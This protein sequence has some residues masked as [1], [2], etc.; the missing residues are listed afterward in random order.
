MEPIVKGM[1][2]AAVE[3]VQDRLVS[4]GYT[5]SQQERDACEFG[6]TT[7]AAVAAFRAAQRLDPGIEVDD[8][9]WSVLVDECYSLGDRTLYL[10]LPNFHGRDVRELQNALNILGFS[11]GSTDGYYDP[12]TESA[13]KQ[14]QDS[15]GLLADGLAFP[16]TFAAI[17]SLHHVWA[18][19]P[20]EGPHPTGDI[21]F[22]RAAVVLESTQISITAEDPITRNV[23]GRVWNLAS[24]TTDASRLALV[25]NAQEG[26]PDDTCLLILSS[27]AAKTRAKTPRVILEDVDTLPQR[28]RTAFRSSRAKVPTVRIALPASIG[29]DGSFTTRD[30]QAL[31]VMLLDGIC[32]AFAEHPL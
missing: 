17:E 5:I 22:A 13:V 10:R 11:C 15:V 21:G 18:G 24:A 16:D 25:E 23:A 1:S 14:F 20:A 8:A 7:L 28:I 9:T 6:D 32:A 12:H 4:L 19:K 30:A 27:A 31:A 26:R 3:D 29:Y 2:G